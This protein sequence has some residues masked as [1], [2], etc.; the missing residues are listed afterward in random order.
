MGIIEGQENV[1][2]FAFK[3]KGHLLGGSTLAAFKKR[4][5]GAKVSWRQ[6]QKVLGCQLGERNYEGW[7]RDEVSHEEW[8]RDLQER[9][10]LNQTVTT[11]KEGL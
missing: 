10:Q 8:L 5:E 6:L 2:D 1:L 9:S 3:E 11:I 7:V 4:G